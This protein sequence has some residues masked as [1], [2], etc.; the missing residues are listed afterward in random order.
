MY[1]GSE[2]LFA[3]HASELPAPIREVRADAAIAEALALYA[4]VL[5][6]RG[7][8]YGSIPSSSLTGQPYCGT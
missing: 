5:L 2:L 8:W 4:G 6:A 1:A 7:P 3:C